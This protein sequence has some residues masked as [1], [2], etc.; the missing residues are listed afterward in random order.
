MYMND[1]SDS[2]GVCR[3]FGFR[4]HVEDSRVTEDRCKVRPQDRSAQIGRDGRFVKE[5]EQ[6]R[7]MILSITCRS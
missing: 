7:D 6:C 5:A 1:R 3:H 2:E 4:T